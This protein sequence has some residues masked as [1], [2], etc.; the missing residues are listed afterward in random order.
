MKELSTCDLPY[1]GF[2]I[3]FLTD[4]K[5]LKLVKSSFSKEMVTYILSFGE[6]ILTWDI[7]VRTMEF[8]NKKKL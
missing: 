4:V 3:L 2:S 1:F 6:R 8:G 7:Q 5:C